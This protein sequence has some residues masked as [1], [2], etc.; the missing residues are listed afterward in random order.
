MTNVEL[1]KR[2]QAMAYKVHEVTH[3]DEYLESSILMGIWDALAHLADDVHELNETM[4]G[5]QD[6]GR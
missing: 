1:F 5:K 6:D 2:N 4:K 3:N